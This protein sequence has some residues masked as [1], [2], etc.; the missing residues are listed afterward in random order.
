MVK[1]GENGEKSVKKKRVE[2]K[3]VKKKSVKKNGKKK[4][5]KKKSVRKIEKKCQKIVKNEFKKSFL[6][7][8]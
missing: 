2:K 8:F 7:E 3:R 1:K 5:V 6:K 4:R